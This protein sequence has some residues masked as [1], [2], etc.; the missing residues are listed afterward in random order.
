PDLAVVGGGYRGAEGE[1]AGAVPD[2][3]GAGAGDA[4]A[5][6]GKPL[7]ADGDVWM[8]FRVEELGGAQVRVTLGDLGVDGGGGHRDDATHLTVRGDG[9]GP[10]DLA[11]AALDRGQAPHA[12]APQADPGPRR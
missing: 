5:G 9:T 8:G 6:G 7:D 3:E 2:G 11:E 10:G 4:L 12:I 1:G